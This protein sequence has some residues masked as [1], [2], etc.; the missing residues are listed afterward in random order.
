MLHSLYNYFR[1]ILAAPSFAPSAEK[2]RWLGSFRA[3]AVAP[4]RALP[5][6]TAPPTGPIPGLKILLIITKMICNHNKFQLKFDSKYSFESWSKWVK[7]YHSSDR[8][9]G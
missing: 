6:S 5:D 1:V 3:E 9:G 7:R 2:R 4:T 8:E